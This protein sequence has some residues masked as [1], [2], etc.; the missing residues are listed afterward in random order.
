MQCPNVVEEVT[1]TLV[2]IKMKMKG[3][4]NFNFYVELKENEVLGRTAAQVTI[5]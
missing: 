1:V 5:K 2:K 3:K 4:S